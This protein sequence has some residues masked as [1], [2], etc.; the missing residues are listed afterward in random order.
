MMTRIVTV[1]Y[2]AHFYL[3][4]LYDMIYGI[5]KRRRERMN[6]DEKKG[7]KLISI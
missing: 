7:D 6:E 4:E 1:F 2:R 5:D 3:V